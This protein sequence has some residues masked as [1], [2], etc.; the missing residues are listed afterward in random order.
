MKKA[1]YAG[2]LALALGAGGSWALRGNG[3]SVPTPGGPTLATVAEPRRTGGA[4][5]AQQLSIR[6]VRPTEDREDGASRSADSSPPPVVTEEERADRIDAGAQL[7][8]RADAARERRRDELLTGLDELAE[9]A[10]ARGDAVYAAN[11]RARAAA[12]EK[13]DR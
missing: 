6:K 13:S 10:E 8:Q 9:Q 2:L 11:L 1:A 3:D 4:A 5:S 7:S 12:L